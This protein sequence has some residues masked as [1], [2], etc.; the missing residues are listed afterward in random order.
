VGGGGRSGSPAL[1]RPWGT[2]SGEKIPTTSTMGRMASDWG[3]D[4]GG[5]SGGEDSAGL[6]AVAYN[7][8]VDPQGFAS[9]PCKSPP[10]FDLHTP[11]TTVPQVWHGMPQLAQYLLKLLPPALSCDDTRSR[12]ACNAAS[13]GRA[14]DHVVPCVV[15][16]V[17]W[18]ILLGWWWGVTRSIARRSQQPQPLDPGPA[19]IQCVQ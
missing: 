13:I 19:G 8:H 6:P 12:S 14:L 16:V 1:R 17:G 2:R 18:W 15:L 7:T 5:G 9:R 3:F 4:G 11:E 10:V